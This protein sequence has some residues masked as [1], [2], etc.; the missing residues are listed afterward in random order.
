MLDDDVFSIDGDT[1]NE[2]HEWISE[3]GSR[4][5]RRY[6]NRSWQAGTVAARLLVRAKP[7][8]CVK[9]NAAL[10][11]D[12]A[13]R[14]RVERS[15]VRSRGHSLRR[16]SRHRSLGWCQTSMRHNVIRTTAF[17]LP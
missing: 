12:M 10:R 4:S 17:F 6:E 15:G 8:A 9:L 16:T 14:E 1:V 13:N 2:K 11:R 3:E 7:A 5:P